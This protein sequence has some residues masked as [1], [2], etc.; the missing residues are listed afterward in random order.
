MGAY[1]V[2]GDHGPVV[3][4]VAESDGR[5]LVHPSA[6]EAA[7]GW[8]VEPQ[9]LC[10]GDVCVPYAAGRP[11]SIGE[12][13]I[14]LHD[15]ADV[16]R[17]PVLVDGDVCVVVVGASAMDRREALRDRQLLELELADLDGVV[18]ASSEWRGSKKLLVAFASW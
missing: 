10:R 16:L 17:R 18:H 3:V 11:A 7:I 6:I 12:D 13:Q 14:D 15:V 2:L 9:G 8:R 4:D 1:T 5:L